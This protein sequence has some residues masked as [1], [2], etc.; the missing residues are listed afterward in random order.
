MLSR[1]TILRIGPN[2]SD[3]T[4]T[5]TNKQP[6]LECVCMA[7]TMAQSPMTF[8]CLRSLSL[9]PLCFQDRYVVWEADAGKKSR[10]DEFSADLKHTNAPAYV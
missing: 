1:R 10:I 2:N 5:A 6:W 7:L 8:F 4:N 3:N 9:E